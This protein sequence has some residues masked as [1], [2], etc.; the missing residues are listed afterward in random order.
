MAAI[1]CIIVVGYNGTRALDIA[2]LR[3]TYQRVYGQPLVLL[4]EQLKPTDMQLADRVLLTDFAPEHLATALPQLRQALEELQL[5]PVGVLPFSDR[6]VVLGAALAEAYGLPGSGTEAALAGIDKR[7]FRRL[8]AA[9][10]DRPEG[11]QPVYSTQVD[12]LSALRDVV[13]QLQGQAFIKP[14]QEGASRGC[15]VIHSLAECEDAWAELSRYRAG[16]VIVETLVEAAREYSWDQVAGARW[17]TEKQTTEG[18]FRAEIQQVVPAPL[19]ELAQRRIDAAGQH[20]ADLVAPRHGAW[21]NEIFWRANQT[22]SAVE[23]NMRPG[24]MQ[25]WHLAMHSFAGFDPW[26][27]WLRWAVEGVEHN[28]PLQQVGYSGVRLIQ[29]PRDGTVLAWPDIA[30][31]ANALGIRLIGGG[32]DKPLGAP[33]STL[34]TDNFSFLGYVMVHHADYA[35]LCRQLLQ[36][37]AA[38]EQRIEIKP[39]Y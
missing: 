36:L 27:A 23:T 7:V 19:P 14:A 8:D 4:V 32:W 29:A 33:A 15:R 11:Y 37:V 22:T 21:H 20:M 17:I 9:C 24:G 34:I 38:L 3:Q 18:R 2:L 13:A 35:T 5:Q 12:S 10:I 30:A 1:K 25:I 28:A 39:V 16:G 31:T 6:G 26:Q